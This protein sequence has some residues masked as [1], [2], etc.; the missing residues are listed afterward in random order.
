MALIVA[1][2]EK[3]AKGPKLVEKYNGGKIHQGVGEGNYL[4]TSHPNA[5]YSS[6]GG[7]KSIESA[8]KEID[9][10]A[11]NQSTKRGTSTGY[12]TKGPK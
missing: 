12:M 7:F 9:K 5:P 2:K 11:T 4:I 6:K 8:R 3:G 10:H 1:T